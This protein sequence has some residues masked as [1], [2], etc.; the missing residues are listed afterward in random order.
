[1]SAL[2]WDILLWGFGRDIFSF[3]FASVSYKYVPKI[4]LKGL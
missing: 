2:V 1:M 3:H 4:L